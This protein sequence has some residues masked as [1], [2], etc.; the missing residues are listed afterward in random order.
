[1]NEE[2]TRRDFIKS[3][4]LVTTA[5]AAG[6]GMAAS[7]VVMAAD[8]APAAASKAPLL[9]TGKIGNLNITRLI[10]GGNLLTRYHHSR[11]QGYIGKLVKSYNSDAKVRETIELAEASGIN[12]LSVNITPAVCKTLND[13]RKNGG[14]IQ[15]ILYTT[16]NIENVAKYKEDIQKM[17]DDGAEAIYIWGCHGDKY[18]A[19]GQLDILGKMVEEI[20][21]HNVPCGMGG[22]DLKVV[23]EIE[24]SKMPVDFYIKTFHHHN[25]SSAPKGDALKGI[26][27]E[28]PG[29]WCNNPDETM[30]FM[31]TVKKPWIAFKIM[32][33]G[34]IPPKDAFA[35]AF[36]NGA[37]FALAG[38]FDFDITEDCQIT[39]DAVAQA[40]GRERPWA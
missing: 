23:Q 20:K 25:Y 21:M 29:H 3:S 22:H 31:K 18:V 26:T 24:K 16:S 33:A 13:H 39:R 5:V 36:K 37:D 4:G 9:P 38:M 10:L 35:Y 19:S 11:G 30:A 14:K 32:A 2:L 34:A 7:S 8:T 1:M 40:Q 27:S 15:W 6:V 28:V 12:T 17:A